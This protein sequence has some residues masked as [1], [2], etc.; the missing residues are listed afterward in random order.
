MNLDNQCAKD[1]FIPKFSIESNIYKTSPLISESVLRQK[2]LE[3][4]LS[5]R[6]IA[7]EFAC[8]THCI[9]SLLIKYKIPRR[10]PCKSQQHSRRVYGKKKLNGQII[11]HKAEQRT[12]ETIK[13][14]YSKEGLYPQAIAKLLDTMKIPTKHQGKGWHHNTVIKILKREGIYNPKSI[15]I[16]KSI[17]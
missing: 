16:R 10:S 15:G 13:N 4:G 11:T 8:S 9:M 12:I 3:H 1:V 6:D 14:M 2:Y 7:M 17:L 5:A